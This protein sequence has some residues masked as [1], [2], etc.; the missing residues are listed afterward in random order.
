MRNPGLGDQLQHKHRDKGEQRE[1]LAIP[2][3]AV[4]NL[5]DGFAIYAISLWKEPD[6]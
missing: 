4:R 6:G 1:A 3:L 5:N 2:S